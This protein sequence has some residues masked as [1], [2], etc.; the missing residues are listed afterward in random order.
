MPLAKASGNSLRASWWQFWSKLVASCGA[1]SLWSSHDLPL[2][3]ASGH[4]HAAEPKGAKPLKPCAR[5]VNEAASAENVLLRGAFCGGIGRGLVRLRRNAQV[6]LDR[7]PAGG[8][9][10]LRIFV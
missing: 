8:K 7:F 2:A 6:R 10:C 1:K 9:L 4:Q 3:S 5:F